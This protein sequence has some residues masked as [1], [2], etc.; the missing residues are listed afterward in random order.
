MK[1]DRILGGLCVIVAAAMFVVARDYSPPISY[2]PVGPRTFPMVLAVLIGIAGA[3]LFI[4]PSAH[5]AAIAR[6]RWLAIAAC[7]VAVLGFALLFQTLGFPLATTLMAVPVGMAFGGSWLKSLIAG[8]GLGL[9]MF[10][11][12]DKVFDVTLPTGLLSF[13]LGGR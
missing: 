13:M 9:G 11:L 6:D 4:R 12:F 1:S 2:E 10:L 8:I 7:T 3:W 5:S